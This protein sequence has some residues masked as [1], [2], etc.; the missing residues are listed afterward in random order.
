MDANTQRADRLRIGVAWTCVALFFLRVIGQIEALLLSPTW[1]PPMENWYSGLI[2]YPLLLPLQIA[3]LML[4]AVG[5]VR[6][7]RE[8]HGDQ[9]QER[10]IE[11]VRVFAFIYFAVMLTRLVIGLMKGAE[12]VVAADGIPIAFHWVLALYLLMVC[13]SNPSAAILP[14]QNAWQD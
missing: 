1:L 7:Q 13:K 14:R 4:M 2:P 10:R 12:D 5:T 11:P 9:S 8:L 6:L 3:I